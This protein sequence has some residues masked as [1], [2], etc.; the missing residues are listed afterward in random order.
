MIYTVVE[1]VKCKQDFKES[2][3]LYGTYAMAK[4]LH[5]L[6]VL[7]SKSFDLISSIKNELSNTHMA[8]V[9]VEELSQDLVEK[10]KYKAFLLFLKK[11]KPRIYEQIMDQSKSIMTTIIN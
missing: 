3:T 1:Y 2:V 5:S 9:L 10:N 6:N 11:E 7:N 4:E 8:S